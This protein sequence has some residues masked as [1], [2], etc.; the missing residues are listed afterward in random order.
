MYLVIDETY[1]SSITKWSIIH[2]LSTAH[3]HHEAESHLVLIFL[4]K[5]YTGFAHMTI[6]LDSNGILKALVLITNQLHVKK[7]S[8]NKCFCEFHYGMLWH[9]LWHVF[10]KPYIHFSLAF[11]KLLCNFE[12]RTDMSVYVLNRL[13]QTFTSYFRCH[14]THMTTQFCICYIDFTYNMKIL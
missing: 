14:G 6:S 3:K 8:H 1:L 12:P 9:W 13:D 4:T 11:L 10:E 7:L 2:F 5:R